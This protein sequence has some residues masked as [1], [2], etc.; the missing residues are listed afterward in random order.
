V[1]LAS[2]A[3]A[4]ESAAM[5]ELI[6]DVGHAGDI[7]QSP[8]RDRGLRFVRR[9]YPMRIFGLA[10]G[11][12]AVGSVLHLHQAGPLAWLLLSA[13]A[14]LWPHLAYQWAR[15]AADPARAERR[16]LILD[17]AFGGAWIAAMQFNLLPSAVLLAMLSMDKVAAGGW[18]L[19]SRSWL[20]MLAGGA[21]VW[22]LLGFPVS[23]DSPMPVVLCSLPLLVGYPLVL[24]LVTWRLGQAV[25]RQNRQLEEHNRTDT[26]TGLPNRQFWRQALEQEFRR[27]FRHGRPAALMMVDIDHFKPIN[28]RQGHLVGDMVLQEFALELR[29]GLRA[30]DI[31]AR[32][33]GDEFAVVM[34]ETGPEGVGQAARRLLGQVRRRAAEPDNDVP[35]SIS[36]GFAVLDRS[37]RS[38]EEWIAAADAALYRAKAAGRNRYSG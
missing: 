14:L 32:Y 22:A 20:G 9:L 4:R 33:G 24:S 23:L 5:P 13:N 27:F 36:L 21:V 6:Q 7:E 16:N 19:L 3:P 29:R 10:A 1:A 18:P 17:S 34:P 12:L 37:H 25:L 35:Y 2:A 30:V 28:D 31:A 11:G 15:V 8:E 26:L 38:P